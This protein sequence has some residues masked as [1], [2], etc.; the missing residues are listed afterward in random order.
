MICLASVKDEFGSWVE[1]ELKRDKKAGQL[2]GYCSNVDELWWRLGLERWQLWR[3]AGQGW[4]LCF[5]CKTSRPCCELKMVTGRKGRSQRR[6]NSFGVKKRSGVFY[7]HL[8]NPRCSKTASCKAILQ[9]RG[10]KKMCTLLK[11]T[12]CL[13]TEMCFILKCVF[14][15]ALALWQCITPRGVFQ[16]WE[17]KCVSIAREREWFKAQS[18]DQSLEF[19]HLTIDHKLCL[20]L[21]LDQNHFNLLE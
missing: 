17:L 16:R 19:G 21:K 8:I 10:S 7:W 14:P 2:G 5:Q 20:Y 11:V 12:Y 13:A 9:T 15:Q 6:L 3:K 1:N 18:M 4:K